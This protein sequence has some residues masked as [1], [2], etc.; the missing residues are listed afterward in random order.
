[1]S[2]SEPIPEN[3]LVNIEAEA[4]LLGALM[5]D[6]RSIDRAADQLTP[7]DFAEAV[8]GRVFSAIVSEY[9]RGRP[10]NPVTLKTILADDPTLTAMGGGAYLG[11]LTGSDVALIGADAFIGQIAELA[12]RRRLIDGLQRTIGLAANP[13][14]NAVDLIDAADAAL[15]EASTKGDPVRTF[16][17]GMALKSVANGDNDNVRAISC[18]SI[19]SMD[20]LLGRPRMSDMVVLA[21]RPGMGKTAAAISYALGAAKNGHGVAFFSLEMSAEQLAER[22][23][24]DLCFNGHGGIP[25]D[26]IRNNALTTEQ[27]MQ[28]AR[29]QQEAAGLPFQII[30]AGHLTVGGLARRVR[31]W[32]RR[33]EAKGQP[34]EL[35]VVD[36]LQLLTPNTKNGNR[37]DEVAE[38]SRELKAIAKENRCVVLALSQ[39]NRSVEHRADKRP[40]LSDL[41]ESGQI[42]QDADAVMF[43]FRLEYYLRNSEPEPNDDDRAKWE[44]SLRACQGRIEFI[45]AKNRHGTTGSAHGEFWGGNQAVR[46]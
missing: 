5:R 2:L 22:M 37:N 12:Q 35:V 31:R 21:G 44:A 20:R 6:N 36:Y 4:A 28:L 16:S 14:T 17:L 30:D 27:R 46:G 11:R 8:Y 24:S 29:V 39:L 40:T 15:L 23:A 32:K 18:N 38:I 42:E 3:P 25:Y 33:M 26:G 9:S 43:L 34:L 45:C 13:E 7:E 19:P 41:R 10:A 1:L